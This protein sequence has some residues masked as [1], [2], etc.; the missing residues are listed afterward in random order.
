MHFQ[1]FQGKAY[2][3]SSQAAAAVNVIDPSLAAP[4]RV[5]LTSVELE[6]RSTESLLPVL[7]RSF[8]IVPTTFETAATPLVDADF[9]VASN[10]SYP[11]T[12][13]TQVPVTQAYGIAVDGGRVWFGAG[14]N[15]ARVDL[16]TIGGP[17]DRSAPVANSAAGPPNDRIRIDIT[18]SNAGTTAI[19]GDALYMY[20][21]G[22]FAAKATF[23]L[24]PGAT[25]VLQ[26]A[27]G[28]VAE[29]P[30]PRQRVRAIARVGRQRRR[31]PGERPDDARDARRG[32]RTA[33]PP[34]R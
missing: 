15:L 5:T 34:T 18:V 20:S 29:Q 1:F 14:G 6:V 27:F 4:F 10:Q 28:N 26:D 23:A 24:A 13:V 11:G 3:T 31:P 32:R 12:L 21:P 22:T 8:P 19:T 2:V 30:V 9:R 25:Q 7:N 16:Q 17:T 33:M